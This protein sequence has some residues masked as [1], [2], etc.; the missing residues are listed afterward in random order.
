M[1]RS[2]TT[3][4]DAALS[5]GLK[6]LGEIAAFLGAGLDATEILA[7][8]AGALRRGL[9]LPACAIWIRTPDGL[10]FRSV[11]AV[12]DPAPSPDVAVLVAKWASGEA[13]VPEDKRV[14]RA[15]LVHAGERLGL[16]EA[17]LPRE[18]GEAAE[19]LKVVANILSPLL[20]SIELSEDLASEVALRTREIDAQRRFTAKI[21][22]SLPVGLYAIDR[23][24]RIQ[25]WNRKR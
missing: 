2:V 18:P 24:Y 1:A 22:D 4:S 3:T 8:V 12:G 19:I 14:V 23:D 7:G 16:L 17:E 6:V 20:G 10:A 25:A 5:P 15:P 13:P 9:D 11:T 21:I